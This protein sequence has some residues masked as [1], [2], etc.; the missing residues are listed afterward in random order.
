MR[1][2]MSVCRCRK[3]E[4]LSILQGANQNTAN[5]PFC[6]RM[7]E[8]TPIVPLNLYFAVLIA[9]V[10]CITLKRRLLIRYR[11]YGHGVCHMLTELVL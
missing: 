4:A 2:S 5:R 6:H 8:R 1:T 3:T 9:F 7:D 11:S 10:F